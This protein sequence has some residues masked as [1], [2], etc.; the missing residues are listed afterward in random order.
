[1]LSI[2]ATDTTAYKGNGQD[3]NWTIV[4]SIVAN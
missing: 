1:M 2:D 4:S 3:C